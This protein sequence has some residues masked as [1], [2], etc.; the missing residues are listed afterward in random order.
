M[1]NSDRLHRLFML[2]FWDASIGNSIL[3]NLRNIY[4]HIHASIINMR[5]FTHIHAYTRERGRTL[6]HTHIPVS[7]SNKNEPSSHINYLN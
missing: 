1:I 3:R 7:K 2:R 4:T 6:S 5:T